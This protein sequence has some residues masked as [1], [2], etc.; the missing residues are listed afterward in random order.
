MVESKKSE[1][2]MSLKKV[3]SRS[4]EFGFTTGILKGTLFRRR[5]G[6]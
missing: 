1:L 2:K 6:K 4:K 3:R 5:K